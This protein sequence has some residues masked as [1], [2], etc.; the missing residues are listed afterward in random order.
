MARTPTTIV[1]IT[2]REAA[3][4][5]VLAMEPELVASIPIVLFARGLFVPMEMP[6]AIRPAPG[7]VASRPPPLIANYTI[8]KM[9][10]A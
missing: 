2:V 10:N 8:V 3:K 6:K 4:R 5:T 9:P 7:E 1:L